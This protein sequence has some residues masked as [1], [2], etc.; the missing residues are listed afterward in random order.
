MPYAHL[1]LLHFLKQPPQ[2][3]LSNIGLTQYPLQHISEYWQLFPHLPQLNLL[4]LKS[5]H[6]SRQ[7]AGPE[8]P[9]RRHTLGLLSHVI[10]ALRFQPFLPRVQAINRPYLSRWFA[11]TLSG[12]LSVKPM[13][14][15]TRTTTTKLDILN[16]FI[17]LSPFQNLK[18]RKCKHFFVWKCVLAC[19]CMCMNVFGWRGNKGREWYLYTREWCHRS[20][21]KCLKN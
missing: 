21:K 1:P 17:L 5:T 11:S 14:K 10:A 4:V 20:T 15:T 19:V 12:S 8:L 7:Q 18:E 3:L 9:L 16:V 2:C 13:A 6:L